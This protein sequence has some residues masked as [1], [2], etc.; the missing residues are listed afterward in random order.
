M[1]K[2]VGDAMTANPRTLDVRASVLDAA[3]AMQEEDVG[4]VPVVDADKVL[5]GMITDRDIVVRAAAEARDMSTTP[6]EDVCSHHVEDVNV[7]D[8]ANQAVM[9][10]RARA[11]R[12]VPVTDEDRL[13]GVVALSDMAVERDGQS[14]LADISV[15]TPNR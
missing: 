14:A 1:G 11:V 8:D 9:L 12:R 3:R 6:V 4:S 10:M 5:H 13:V 2:L 7:N 15:A